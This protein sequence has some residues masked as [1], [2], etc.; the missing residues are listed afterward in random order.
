MAELRVA[1]AEADGEGG[2]EAVGRFEY[3]QG[4]AGADQ[5]GAGLQ[6]LLEGR[7]EAC[8]AGEAFG[9]FVQ[10]GEVGDPAGEAVL[11]DRAGGGRMRGSGCRCG[12][13]ASGRGRGSVRGS[14]NCWIDSSHFRQMRGAH[15]I[16][17]STWCDSP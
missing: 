6:D 4:A 12:G 14:R 1:E 17:L 3:G 7:V 10:G 16:R 11:D 15:G 5:C 13:R 8:R 9:E 2:A